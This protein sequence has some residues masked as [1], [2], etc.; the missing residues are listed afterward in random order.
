MATI[1]LIGADRCFD[2]RQS[3]QVAPRAAAAEAVGDI[4]HRLDPVDGL[5]VTTL[6]ERLEPPMGVVID[7]RHDLGIVARGAW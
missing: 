7:L 3:D 6:G 4:A 1:D 2:Q 5:L